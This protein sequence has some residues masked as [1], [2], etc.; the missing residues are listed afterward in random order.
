MRPQNIIPLQRCPSLVIVTDTPKGRGIFTSASI[1]AKTILDICPVLLL[2]PEENKEHIEHTSIYH[3]T[4]NWPLTTPTG[5]KTTTQALVFGLGSMFNHSSV[6]QNV[7]WERDV[8]RNVITY[9]ALRDI[10]AGEELCISYGSHLT[11][12]DTD[13]PAAEPEGDGTDQ[14]NQIQL[15]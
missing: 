9:W 6:A 12:T 1:P 4:Y 5:T 3:Y 15:D 13:T 2:S 11:F 8:E 10:D 7:V 14:L